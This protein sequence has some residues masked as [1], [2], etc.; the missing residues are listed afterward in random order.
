MKPHPSRKTESDIKYVLVL[1]RRV[2]ENP[3]IDFSC[4]SKIVFKL[5]FYYRLITFCV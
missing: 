1:D 4:K 2:I 3:Y 5:N